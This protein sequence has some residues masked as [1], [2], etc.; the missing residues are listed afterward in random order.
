MRES[1]SIPSTIAPDPRLA[2]ESAIDGRPLTVTA[3]TPLAEVLQSMG[4]AQSSCNLPGLE[5]SLNA[6]LRRQV[7]AEAVWVVEQQQLL[8]W[9]SQGDAL[10]AIA[11]GMANST[12]PIADCMQTPAATLTLADSTGLFEALELLR[13]FSLPQLPVLDQQRQFLGVVTP[14]GLRGGL[15]LDEFLKTQSVERVLQA[16]ILQVP[17]S[18]SAFSLVQQLADQAADCAVLT[19]AASDRSTVPAGIVQQ[20][21]LLQLYILGLDLTQLSL[22]TVMDDQLLILPPH[23][24]MLTAYWIMQQRQVQRFVVGHE[25]GELLGIVSPTHFLYTLD[26][27]EMAQAHAAVQRSLQQFAVSQPPRPQPDTPPVEY[28]LA[29]LREQLES[30]Q[31]LSKMALHI[32]QSLELKTILQTAVTEVRQFLRSD[33]VLV[34]QFNS[35]MSGTVVVESRLEQWPSVLDSTVTDTCF[36]QYYAA[37]Y[38]AGRTQVVEDIYTAD[39]SQCHIDILVLFDVRASL[40]V[41]ILQGQ[42]LW[43]LL[44]AYQ[45]SGPRHWRTFE[46]NLLKQ[47]ATHVAIAIQQSGL[48]QQVQTELQERQRIE[49]QLKASLREKESLLK[50]IHHRVKNNLQII[51]SVLRLQ[52]DYIKDE[53]VMALFKDSQNRIRSMALIHE[54]L[55]KSRD[56]LHIHMADYI[57]DLTASLMPSFRTGTHDV[58]LEIHADDIY[59]SIDTAIPCGLIINE[60]V[61]NALKHAFPTT[62]EEE[63]QIQVQ[64]QPAATARQFILTV[65]DNGIGFPQ[66]IDFR[67]TE[68]LGLELVCVFTEQLEG[69]IDLVPDR[70]TRFVVT[71]TEIGNLEGAE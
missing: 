3:A 40:V 56:L 36:G 34:Y 21:D 24:S 32:R 29:E 23:E 51:S 26:L 46:V 70:G 6:G 31:L 67:N 54:K 19:A 59:L 5:L 49:Q 55:Y 2:L 12:Q 17:A 8:G 27:G 42:H 48:Y 62:L 43:G 41:P 11:T 35:D 37:D 28:E 33:R 69:T 9:F 4:K 18:T 50:E 60:L 22:S 39:L 52:S 61:S 44:C 64:I 1:S 25:G 13:Q 30:S 20:R 66:D 10:R 38:Q 68:S 16:P 7:R 53:Q 14:E 65:S 71:F 47:L 45:C 58:N 57:Q 63:N 15:Y